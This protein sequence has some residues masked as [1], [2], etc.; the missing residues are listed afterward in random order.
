MRLSP[1]WAGT[2]EEALPPDGGPTAGEGAV[3][4]GAA[5]YVAA[6]IAPTRSHSSLVR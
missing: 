3:K 6:S 1:A 2:H 4:V 5:G